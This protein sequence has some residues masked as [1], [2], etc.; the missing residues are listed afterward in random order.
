MQLPEYMWVDDTN[1][2]EGAMKKAFPSLQNVLEDATHGMRRYARSLPDGHYGI[3]RFMG[4]LSRAFFVVVESDREQLK[5][6]LMEAE[7]W[8]ASG[9]HLRATAEKI[10]RSRCRHTIPQAKE[11]RKRV[12]KVVADHSNVLDPITGRSLFTEETFKVHHSM[13]ALIDAGK[14]SDPLPADQM[15]LRLNSGK[16]DKFI[17]L[18][19][20]SK[21]EGFHCHIAKVLQGN[22]F[23]PDAAGALMADFTHAWNIDRAI[24]NK[25]GTVNYGCYD[26]QLM[27][28]INGLCTDLKL[29]LQFSQLKPTPMLKNIPPMFT[30]A[31]PPELIPV[32]C[33]PEGGIAPLNGAVVEADDA[34]VAIEEFENDVPPF[35]LQSS[36]A[37]ATAPPALAVPVAAV[38]VAASPAAENADI[39][40][41]KT[42]EMLGTE[43]EP[44]SSQLVEQQ[45]GQEEPERSVLKGTVVQVQ[46][47]Q[48]LLEVI[49][50]N[51][52]PVDAINTR[53]PSK[54]GKRGRGRPRKSSTTPKSREKEELPVA[55]PLSQSTFSSSP[56]AVRRLPR[57]KRNAMP[58]DYSG[59]V[60]TEEEIRL[61]M[62]CIGD[63]IASPTLRS[64]KKQRTIASNFN[65]ALQQQLLEDPNSTAGMSFKQAKHVKEFLQRSTESLAVAATNQ[66]VLFNQERDQ[67]PAPLAPGG[68]A[69][70]TQVTQQPL[71]RNFG[72]DMGM[73]ALQQPAMPVS[74]LEAVQQQQQAPWWPTPMQQP[75]MPSQHGPGPYYPAPMHP[76][77]PYPGYG[78]YPNLDPAALVQAAAALLQAQQQQPLAARGKG[79]KGAPG[80]PRNCGKCFKPLKGKDKEEGAC[81][82]KSN[83]VQQ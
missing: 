29:P 17:G 40:N 7:R 24:T 16:K 69:Y 9:T 37:M 3:K 11:L 30:L 38:A 39:S 73:M 48:Q 32:L 18:R 25:Q 81:F 64:P 51:P 60:Q 41:S 5:K 67:A 53:S 70:P 44:L 59:H 71:S 76:H 35:F 66:Q 63:D 61:M 55:L 22:R 8:G 15:F 74:Q 14:F 82:C 80:K 26:T 31:V 65:S 12:E 6:E 2:M 54:Q 10:L 33:P 79:G 28:K 36:G 43:V 83:A 27:E 20:T 4:D 77:I 19:G 49:A 56:A 75:A 23:S 1:Q 47:E 13:L 57:A 72:V 68:A 46:Q 42:V 58:V 21:L 52:E 62:A 78:M 50:I 34:R 45:Q